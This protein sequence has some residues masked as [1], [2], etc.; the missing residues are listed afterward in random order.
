M[1]KPIT[2]DD[3]N[4]DRTVLQ[5]KIPVLV[6]FWAPWCGPCKTLAPRVRQLSKMFQGKVAFGKVNIDNYKELA[7]QFHILGIPNLVFFSYGEKVTNFMGI[8][9]IKDIQEKIDELLSRFD[10]K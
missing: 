3:S 10:G 7:K 5:A 8:K 1:N 6:D 2:I 9:P 4:F